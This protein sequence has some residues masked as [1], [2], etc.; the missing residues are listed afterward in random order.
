MTTE[1]TTNDTNNQETTMTTTDT[2]TQTRERVRADIADR[3]QDAGSDHNRRHVA[4]ILEGMLKHT[5]DPYDNERTPDLE[6]PREA[7][8]ADFWTM[9]ERHPNPD[10]RLTPRDGSPDYVDALSDVHDY[11]ARQLNSSEILVLE[12]Y[13][14]PDR[15]DPEQWVPIYDERFDVAAV[16]LSSGVDLSAEDALY[17]VKRDRAEAYDDAAAHEIVT[18]WPR[19]ADNP[20]P[21]DFDGFARMVYAPTRQRRSEVRA[22]LIDHLVEHAPALQDDDDLAPVDDLKRR[23]R[24]KAELMA[25]PFDGLVKYAAHLGVQS[26]PAQFVARFR[27]RTITRYGIVEADAW[28]AWCQ[29]AHAQRAPFRLYGGERSR[30]MSGQRST[31][32]RRIGRKVVID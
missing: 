2:T 3:F 18:Y 32:S 19:A 27:H 5:A 23:D 9:G 8:M 4:D 25:T 26:L 21:A 29:D 7:T 11:V 17:F 13:N 16:R 22:A 24:I 15:F 20:T 1:P 6:D 30:S 14:C 10:W 31:R 12:R 28:A